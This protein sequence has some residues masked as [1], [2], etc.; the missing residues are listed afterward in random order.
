M[1]TNRAALPWYG[2]PTNF[3]SFSLA[4]AL[5][6]VPV[7]P[8]ST[9]PLTVSITNRAETREQFDLEIEGLDP[10][11]TAV[12]VAVFEIGPGETR[13]EKVLFR[14]ARSSESLAGAYPF[15]VKVR[16]LE[17]GVA[18]QSQGILDVRPFNGI[19]AELSPKKGKYSPVN[20]QNTFTVTLLN[21]GNTAHT[22][23]LTGNDPE[24][25]C[26]YEFE[27]EHITLNPG[28]QREVS[29]VVKPRRGLA[30]ASGRLIGFGITARSQ[31]VPSVSAGVQGQLEQRGLFSP[32]SL[33]A[34]V[35][36]AIL[37][38]F[39]YLNLPKPPTISL[40]IE[41]AR[42]VQGSPVTLKWTAAERSRVKITIPDGTV[43]YDGTDTSGSLSYNVTQQA[44]LTF[45]AVAT[46]DNVSSP[47]DTETITIDA[48][49]QIDPPSLKVTASTREVALGTG[50]ILN[51]EVG[52]S[53]VSA[54]VAPLG[55]DLDL[56]QKQLEIIP[57]RIGWNEYTVSAKNKAG[58]AKTQTVRVMVTQVSAAKIIAFAADK[59]TVSDLENMVTLNWQVTNAARVE[60][61]NGAAAPQVVS[62]EG[63]Q[64]VPVMAKTTFVLVA[65]DADGVKTNQKI[66]IVRDNPT[67]PVGPSPDDGGFPD[68][69]PPISTGTTA[70]TVGGGNPPPAPRTTGNR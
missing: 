19:S 12:P 46:R 68:S 34:I 55:K 43:I 17:S 13:Q 60:L 26:A 36:L 16:S 22:L 64:T 41:P 37:G 65:T 62:A 14:I 61:I 25:A 1:V 35:F 63:S 3:M 10:E 28:Q 42:V 2:Y 57:T 8:G 53:V 5:D 23:Q 69:V 54:T 31:D 40:S 9:V 18:E 24:D 30:V 39:W 51:Y 7:E 4:L 50:F 58:V 6:V 66:T 15:V 49:E 11:W 48:P 56:T 20:Q 44:T 67:K 32:S 33:V 70:G 29:V 21:L 47:P 27:S 59:T 52:P 45:R 38:I